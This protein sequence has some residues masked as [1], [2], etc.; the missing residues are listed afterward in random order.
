V[1]DADKA[2]SVKPR[3]A[4]VSVLIPAYK[5]SK[6][7]ERA[8][9]GVARQTVLPKEV[10]VVVDGPE[11]ETFHAAAAYKNQMGAVVLNVVRQDHQGAGAAR[12]RALAEASG[13]YVA[14][15][16]ADDEWLPDKLER[17]LAHL[18]GSDITFVSHNVR[19]RAGEEEHIVDCVRHFKAESEVLFASIY[20]RGYIST[21]TVVVK[22]KTVIDAGGFDISLATAQDFDLWLSILA[23][24]DVRLHIFDEPLTRNYITEGSITSGTGRRLE[25]CLRIA[26]D[27]LPELKKHAGSAFMSLWFRIVAVHIEAFTAYRMRHQNVKAFMTLARLPFVMAALSFKALWL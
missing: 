24:T 13:T 23:N 10:I 3:I 4:D 9:L 2:S 21:S 19:V 8:L 17:S 12:N 18:E 26:I 1:A 20:R 5:A 7:I 14:F 27:H 11:G 25:C 15:L 16:D 6:T 22:R